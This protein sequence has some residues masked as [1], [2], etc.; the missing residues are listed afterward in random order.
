LAGT[1]RHGPFCENG[2]MMDWLT[3]VIALMHWANIRLRDWKRP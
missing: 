3:I 1:Q 2:A